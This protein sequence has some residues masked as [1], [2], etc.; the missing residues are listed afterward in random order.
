MPEVPNSS[1]RPPDREPPSQR[2][3]GKAQ[4]S[5]MQTRVVK[6]PEH[7]N[8][9]TNPNNYRH[10]P[11]SDYAIQEL[12]R[13]QQRQREH[14]Q[15][16]EKPCVSVASPQ[17]KVQPSQ[18]SLEEEQ[19]YKR[20]QSSV[21]NPYAQIEPPPP[22]SNPYADLNSFNCK[23]NRIMQNAENDAQDSKEEVRM[24]HPKNPYHLLSTNPYKDV[25]PTDIKN[26][27]KNFAPIDTYEGSL[28]K[29]RGVGDMSS[30]RREH[31]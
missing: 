12:V 6:Y 26:P 31:H 20:D 30:I 5:D 8:F 15:P 23:T 18:E 11:K 13:Q 19:S 22:T 1:S 3:Q 14:V 16:N 7:S 4:N 28:S 2:P 27:Y 24:N 17:Q 25:G 10:R 9:A 29:S 21:P